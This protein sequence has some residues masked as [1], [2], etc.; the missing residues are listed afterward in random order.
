MDV[1]VIQNYLLATMAT[2]LL[3]HLFFLE[4]FAWGKRL[5]FITLM[6]RE[7]TSLFQCSRLERLIKDA[8]FLESNR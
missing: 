3:F 5:S 8:S 1:I 7:S 6:K 4:K 2:L